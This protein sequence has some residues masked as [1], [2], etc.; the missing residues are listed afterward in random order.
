MLDEKLVEKAL[1]E[2]LPRQRI[3]LLE[4]TVAANDATFK[5]VRRRAADNPA[6]SSADTMNR[7]ELLAA[8]LKLPAEEATAPSPVA[9]PPAEGEGA[10]KAP[11]AKSKN[12]SQQKQM[13]KKETPAR[14]PSKKGR[15]GG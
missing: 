14:T 8:M 4:K 7:V 11:A 2:V 1:V 3:A 5:E 12:P 10:A 13:P 15:G 9:A 6:I